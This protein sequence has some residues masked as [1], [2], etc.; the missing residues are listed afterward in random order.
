MMF[1]LKAEST[2]STAGLLYLYVSTENFLT[3]LRVS[4]LAFE[5][6]AAANLKTLV[7]A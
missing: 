4:M 1:R 3:S 7:V 2:G 6:I 5:L